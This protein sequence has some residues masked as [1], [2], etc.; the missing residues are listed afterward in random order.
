MKEEKKRLS[1]FGLAILV[2]ALSLSVAGCSFTGRRGI[3]SSSSSSVS[4]DEAD[5]DRQE[6]PDDEDPDEEEPEE[7]SSSQE[8]SSSEESSS[9]SSS[10][11]RTE[12]S[13]PPPAASSSSSSSA[14]AP[15]ASSSAPSASS[16]PA[17][18]NKPSGSSKPSSS[19]AAPV[20]PATLKNVTYI[21]KGAYTKE[22][23]FQ[24]ATIK[25]SGMLIKNKTFYGDVTVTS[26]AG[27]DGITLEDVA[28]KGTLTVQ[29]G[30]DW[31]KL[32]DCSIGS[33]VVDYEGAKVFASQKTSV[34][35]VTVKKD[36]TLQE[37]DLTGNA[38]G[39][40]NIETSG[41]SKDTVGLTLKKLET[42][43]LTTRSRSVVST[44]KDTVIDI[45]N[46]RAATRIKGP[47]EIGELTAYA[48]GVYYDTRPGK[49][50]TSGGAD[51]PRPYGS[52][53]DWDD[54]T[55]S[56][57]DYDWDKKDVSIEPIDDVTLEYGKEVTIRVDSN[58]R[59]LSASSSDRSV[60]A[61]SVG[62]NDDRITISAKKVGKAVITVKG[63]RSG[64]N[65][66]TEKLN[67]TVVSNTSEAPKIT[68][69]S[70]DPAAWTNRDVSISFK[71]TDT[72][73]YE[74]KADGHTWRNGQS[75]Y[76]FTVAKNGEYTIEATD[77][78]GNVTKQTVRITRIDKEAPQILD[79]AAAA[80]QVAFRVTDSG[81]GVSP[82]KV[83]ITA[84]DG[85]AFSPTLQNGVYRFNGQHGKTYAINAADEA[86]NAAEPK[87]ITVQADPK[88]VFSSKP[89]VTDADAYKPQKQV[90][91]AITYPDGQ[92]PSVTIEPAIAG[93]LQKL[94][95]APA[96]EGY[97][98]AS[99]IFTVTVPGSYNIVA[100]NSAGS[101][102]EPVSV[103]KIDKD[104][105]VI[106]GII[107]ENAADTRPE[108]K[109]SFRATDAG[110]GLQT[111]TVDGGVTLTGPDSAGNCFF[112]A[113]ANRVYTITA[114]DKAGNRSTQTVEVSGIGTPTAPE[115]PAAAFSPLTLIPAPPAFTNG[116]VKV[117]F[118]VTSSA[119]ETVKVEY[120]GTVQ[121]LQKLSDGSYQ[122][123]AAAK[124]LYNITV[125][126]GSK[127]PA[128]Q[129]VDIAHIDKDKPVFDNLK[130]D[131]PTKTVTF[132]LIDA[133]S[134]IQSV[135]VGDGTTVDSSITVTGPDAGGNCSF[136]A[137]QAGS[138]VIT[139]TDKAGNISTQPAVIENTGA[140]N[141]PQPPAGPDA[142]AQ[143]A[144]SDLDY[145]RT[146]S[147]PVKQVYFKI[148]GIAADAIQ[149]VTS[150]DNRLI[151]PL[152]DGR[153]WFSAAQPNYTLIITTTSG[154][155]IRREITIEGISAP[156]AKITG[157]NPTGWTAKAAIVRFTVEP[158]VPLTSITVTGGATVQQD[159]SGYFFEAPSK[160]EYTVSVQNG[161]AAPSTHTFQVSN[162][163]PTP[164]S[165]TI[166]NQDVLSRTAAKALEKTVSFTVQAGESMKDGTVSVSP[167]P[168]SEP[169]LGSDGRYTF[170][171]GRNDTYTVTATNGAGVSGSA[172]I[173]VESIGPDPSM[174]GEPKCSPAAGTWTNG[175]VT[176]SFTVQNAGSLTVQVS[177]EAG[178]TG[179]G[180]NYSFRAPA[181]GAYTITLTDGN[182]ETATRKV[183]I[184]NIDK[185]VPAAAPALLSQDG[186]QTV[187]AAAAIT[188]ANPTF[189]VSL[190][191]SEPGQSPVSAQY[192]LD[193]VTW[194]AVPANPLT[195]T[196][197]SL[198]LPPLAAGTSSVSHTL[199]LRS[200]DAAGNA[201][202]PAVYTILLKAENT[203]AQPEEPEEPEATGE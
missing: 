134:G 11:S 182:G 2:L 155:V 193:G 187:L 95:D 31:L 122:F 181:N 113:N 85:S 43:K 37:G 10:S 97:R 67:V 114:A 112:T 20:T 24:N 8:E 45:F 145:D 131:S 164:V 5:P 14:P 175:D 159:S 57:D 86:G 188:T 13:S 177:P 29:G 53:S 66:D 168:K 19:S 25:G 3:D 82:A 174:I 165:V 61:V 176:V 107:V 22:E 197:S 185:A 38:S 189:S 16:A 169:V 32:Y 1:T 200:V 140:S 28:V 198:T 94:T 120:Q 141:N 137:A 184:S 142:G 171:A 118:R 203:P 146:S 74:V 163:D 12:S 195:P 98:V 41:S 127:Q 93:G 84:S 9:G 156:Q 75:S 109:V 59:S 167:A 194:N 101:V 99:Y 126:N 92:E 54:E 88:P 55:S 62:S 65:S 148:T 180:G 52:D 80:L 151:T 190:P 89:A 103:A 90:S 143:V 135:T 116:P 150:E 152:P 76:S 172:S 186:K 73:L 6:V 78:K 173:K 96:A 179:S 63:T 69:V 26:K 21:Q 49:L 79:L 105:P 72:D 129:S 130:V 48:D 111:V 104:G 50:Y 117:S 158:T 136:T 68:V 100:A 34:G 147:T 149:S 166:L 139:A 23:S 70:G 106:D 183:E 157:A 51:R 178:L 7:D 133:G 191:A 36:A 81:S 119:P 110:A 83:Q 58:A 161:S 18:G 202:T 47:G 201:G 138:Y 132:H 115:I 44:D 108:K 123:E 60:A 196:A 39:F 15:A 125:E 121:T 162:I 170:T 35:S 128:V 192:S 124:G 42:N 153:Y 56:K 64:Y 27:D 17:A 77:A 4:E 30:S 87:T 154:E 144:I 91:F 71:V 199:S 33:L 102:T 160:G 40:E 46:A